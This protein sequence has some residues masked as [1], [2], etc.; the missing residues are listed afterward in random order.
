MRIFAAAK[1]SLIVFIYINDLS[2]ELSSNLRL[3]EDNTFLFLVAW[4]KNLSVNA[5]NSDL[6]KIETVN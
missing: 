4:D 5:L 2:N 1:G 6:L 3:F